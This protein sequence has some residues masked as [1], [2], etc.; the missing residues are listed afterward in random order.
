MSKCINCGEEGPHFVPPSLGEPGF[1][2]C[3]KADYVK[4]RKEPWP[5]KHCTCTA[6]DAP[7]KEC[8]VHGEAP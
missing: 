6:F 8:P 4:G 2:H 3:K 7:G 1:F 5:P